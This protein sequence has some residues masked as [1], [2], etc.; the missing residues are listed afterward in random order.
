MPI[1]DLPG[2]WFLVADAGVFQQIAGMPGAT[3]RVEIGG[4]GDKNRP[5]RRGQAHRHHARGQDIA[6]PDPRVTA[7]TVDVVQFLTPGQVKVAARMCR[8]KPVD[9]RRQRHHIGSA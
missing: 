2:A 7:F 3:G 6:Q 5:Q 1:G 8:Q 4:R 9:H